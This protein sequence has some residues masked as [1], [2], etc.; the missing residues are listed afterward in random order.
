MRMLPQPPHLLLVQVCVR[1]PAGT[2]RKD[3]A[4]EIAPRLLSVAL[5]AGAGGE[6]GAAGGSSLAK[7]P[8]YAA[9]RPDE[10]TWT[11]GSDKHGAHV[12]VMLEKHEQQTWTKLEAGG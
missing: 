4:I 12:A 9:V 3:L 8:L 10:V 1:L 7:I 6:G 2:T 11:L 5:R